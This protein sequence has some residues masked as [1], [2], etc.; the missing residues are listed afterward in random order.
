[1]PSPTR[2][3]RVRSKKTAPS[4]EPRR[5]RP[6][7]QHAR[8]RARSWRVRRVQVPTLTPS[9][10][11]DEA[12]LA[13]ASPPIPPSSDDSSALTA[14]ITS[15]RASNL[16]YNASFLGGS[17]KPRLASAIVALCAL[18]AVALVLLSPALWLNTTST[19]CL[20]AASKTWAR[21]VLQNETF[22]VE[23][24]VDTPP[25]PLS[26]YTWARCASMPSHRAD[27]A[28]TGYKSATPNTWLPQEITARLNAPAINLL[29]AGIDTRLH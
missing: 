23:S 16:V 10:D 22:Y 7:N 15:E 6:G 13:E 29:A 9:A 19:A 20:N 28:D 5:S 4:A 25:I 1:M 2:T 24:K 8:D 12:V 26:A 11:T 18:A 17:V 3:P 21:T 27:T 14:R